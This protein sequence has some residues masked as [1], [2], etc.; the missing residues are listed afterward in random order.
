M[1]KEACDDPKAFFDK[2]ANEIHWFKKYTN[3][4]IQYKENMILFRF[5]MRAKLLCIDGT[6]MEKPTCATIA[7]IDTS[8][9]D[10]ETTLHLFMIVPT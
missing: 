3:V 8:R 5:L 9:Q 10:V 4:T 2:Q 7:W 1:Y 6:L